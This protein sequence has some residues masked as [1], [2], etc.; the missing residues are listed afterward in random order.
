MNIIQKQK[1]RNAV[2]ALVDSMSD[3]DRKEESVQVCH[4]L[5]RE[6]P[7][8]AK[9]CAFY[10]LS[11]EPNIRPF[12]GEM[13]ERGNEVYLPRFDDKSIK[14]YKIDR[15][16]DLEESELG[17]PEPSADLQ[18]LDRT[19]VDLVLVPGRAFDENGNR[20]GRGAGGYDKWI[21]EQR[22][23]DTVTEFVAVAYNCQMV[24]EVPVEPHDQQMDTIISPEKVQRM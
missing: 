4:N 13:L 18:A 15:L 21:E 2:N 9:V 6:I 11:N 1:L 19:H 23:T 10:P 22:V 16:Q 8:D 17:I 3:D 5:L 14:F 24:P 12:I 20:L 7:E